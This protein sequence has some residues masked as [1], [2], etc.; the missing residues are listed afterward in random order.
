VHW[1]NVDAAYKDSVLIVPL[2]ADSSATVTSY[3]GHRFIV[4][5]PDDTNHASPVSEFYVVSGVRKYNVGNPKVID[6][7]INSIAIPMRGPKTTSMS[8]KFKSLYPAKLT[9]WYDD[10]EDGMFGY[11][12]SI[13]L[14]I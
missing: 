6:L 2:E 13:Y 7:D 10:G 1:L 4:V 11:Y 9:R 3:N 14:C 12:S 5:S 8:A